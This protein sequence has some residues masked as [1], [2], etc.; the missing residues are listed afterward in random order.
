MSP[1]TNSWGPFSAKNFL[2][3]RVCN[4]DVT[5]GYPTGGVK[6]GCG[7]GSPY[8]H[9]F[10][11]ARAAVGSISKIGQFFDH[12]DFGKYEPG[13]L[14]VGPIFGAHSWGPKKPGGGVVIN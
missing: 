6:E 8:L 1:V 3:T 10:G 4:I 11:S 12:L 9:F 2:K 5:F 14:C 7:T 13:H